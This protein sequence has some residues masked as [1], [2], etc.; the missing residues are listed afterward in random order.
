MFTS[1]RIFIRFSHRLLSSD[2]QKFL[3]AIVG[4]RL[5]SRSFPVN[6]FQA[7]EKLRTA[8]LRVSQ[9]ADP[10]ILH[11]FAYLNIQRF[12]DGD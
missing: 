5:H 9:R 3:F 6:L 7:L 11:Q 8:F 10:E 12:N 1:I 2:H 4:D